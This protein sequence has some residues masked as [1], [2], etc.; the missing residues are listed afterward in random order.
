MGRPWVMLVVH[1]LGSPC[2]SHGYRCNSGSRNTALSG[3]ISHG[4]VFVGGGGL[5]ACASFHSSAKVVFI[6]ALLARGCCPEISRCDCSTLGSEV[7]RI[8]AMVL[9]AV[10]IV[11]AAQPSIVGTALGVGGRDWN[12]GM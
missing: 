8:M 2:G 9:T 7:G 5:E 10:T 3:L 11:I 1:Q 4:P 6:V 12:L